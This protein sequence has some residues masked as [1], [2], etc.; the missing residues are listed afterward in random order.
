MH[1]RLFALLVLVPVFAFAQTDTASLL[2]AQIAAIEAQIR[3]L[4]AGGSTGA[5]ATRTCPTLTRSLYRGLS[6][7]DVRSLQDFLRSEGVFFEESTG[8][9]GA[10]TEAAVKEWQVARGVVNPNGDISGWGIVGPKTRAAIAQRCSSSGAPGPGATTIVVNPLNSPAPIP[11]APAPA[12]AASSTQGAYAA[13]EQLASGTSATGTAVASRPNRAPTIFGID[14]PSELEV[15]MRGVFTVLADDADDDR[16]LYDMTWGESTPLDALYA[17]AG[18]EPSSPYSVFSHTYGTAGLYT[19][20]ATVRD[21]RGGTTKTTRIIRVRPVST[22]CPGCATST[23]LYEQPPPTQIQI[24]SGI[25]SC[26]TPW[27]G[28]ILQTGGTTTAE[29][30]FRGSVSFTGEAPQMRCVA[31]RWQRCSPQGTNC[32]AHTPPATNQSMASLRRYAD[33]VGS[34]GCTPGGLTVRTEA[35]S[36][37]CANVI[38]QAQQ[39]RCAYTQEETAV[40]LFCSY[41][42]WA[43]RLTLQ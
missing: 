30:Y 42:N 19:L 34:P 21:S 8:F 40:E 23:P 13:L 41:N 14:G 18:L 36:L 3:A 38:H 28:I 16:L 4:Q 9:F 33:V 11:P 6:G 31:G 32:V 37:L 24:P 39:G 25:T 26:A 35:R 15:G 12:T 5:G 7:A 17:L 22:S 10:I 27:G 1:V 2:K 43:E 29:T 20:T